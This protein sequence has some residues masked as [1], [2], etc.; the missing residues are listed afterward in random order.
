MKSLQKQGKGAFL[1]SCILVLF[2]SATFMSCGK[3]PT[4]EGGNIAFSYDTDKWEL[5][6]TDTEPDVTFSLQSDDSSII[7]M[8]I[9]GDA[10]VVDY[11]HD[12]MIDLLQT[13]YE[14]TEKGKTD[15]WD[16]QSWCYYEDFINADEQETMI[17]YAK[18]V[19]GKILVGFSGIILSE[20][21]EKNAALVDEVLSIFNS[22]EYS[23]KTELGDIVQDEDS[24]FAEYLYNDLNIIL[25]FE[26]DNTDDDELSTTEEHISNEEFSELEYIEK[27]TM[28][29]YNGNELDYY[30]YVPVGNSGCDEGYV[31]YGEHGLFYTAFL[32]YNFGANSFLYTFLEDNINFSV[33]FW[34][35][36][37]NGYKDIQIGEIQKNGNDR[38]QII[39]AKKEDYNGNSYEIKKISYMD[40]L[41]TGVG[42]LWELE[43]S[44]NEMD[45]ESTLIIEELAKCYNINPD[46]LQFSGE[47]AINDMEYS[48]NQQDVYTPADGDNVLEKVDGYEYMGLT[49]LI[50]YNEYI[51]CPVM[52]P[53]GWRTSTWDTFVSSSLHGISVS[54][55]LEW[56]TEE[57]FLTCSN[58]WADAEFKD[59]IDD[60]NRNR[61]VIKSETIMLPEYDKGACYVVFTY[62]Q[63]SAITDE[64]VPMTDIMCFI[65][66]NDDYFLSYMII[67]SQEE[68]DASTNTVLKEL[69]EAY[70]I[71]LSEYYYE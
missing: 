15:Q 17:T 70:G 51:E 20:S 38:Y 36:E 60:T 56:L 18:E 41:D 58:R 29:D 71:D 45:P 19:D 69:E 64:Y 28:E 44:E 65:R 3:K 63:K 46:E 61:N 66:V 9:E 2:L 52:I 34:N 6:Y 27:V 24:S 21:E 30:A 62:E 11:F 43:I 50:G 42:V 8:T 37:D 49:T 47:W 55:I 12:D 33:R 5:S 7:I 22:I 32:Y 48:I 59:L 40:V 53:M 1:T 54:G 35:D 67:L 26:I 68:Y 16:S 23:D 39:S 13:D 57:D 25:N 4:Y 10:A 31:S 14:V